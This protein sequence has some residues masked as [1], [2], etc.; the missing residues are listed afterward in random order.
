MKNGHSPKLAFGQKFQPYLL[1][2]VCLDWAATFETENSTVPDRDVGFG[3]IFIYC[4]QGLESD[5]RGIFSFFLRSFPS[6]CR[7]HSLPVG[8]GGD[9]LHFD[10]GSC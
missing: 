5:T 8:W 2:P 4:S 10:R 7:S 3:G 6:P 1:A 9:S